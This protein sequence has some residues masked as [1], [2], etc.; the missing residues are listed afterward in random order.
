LDCPANCKLI[1]LSNNKDFAIV[2]E[3]HYE[4]V[5]KAGPWHLTTSGSCTYAT[6]SIPTGRREWK[7]SGGYKGW[8]LEYKMTHLHAFIMGKSKNLID[9]INCNGLDCREENLRLTTKSGNNLNKINVPRNNTSGHIG[10]SWSCEKNKW[11]AYIQYNYKLHHLGYYSS[12]EEAISARKQKQ[13][14]FI[15]LEIEKTHKEKSAA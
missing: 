15:Q 11:H 7:K 1:P 13:E 2:D 10:V 14:E 5:V 3:K 4:R 9:H 12:L 6:N 8:H